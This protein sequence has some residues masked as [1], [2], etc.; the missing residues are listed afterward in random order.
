MNRLAVKLD[1]PSIT[2]DALRITEATG[3][4]AMDDRMPKL[5]E[6]DD[7]AVLLDGAGA[8]PCPA[9]DQHQHDR[10]IEIR[11]A[12]GEHIP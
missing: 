4:E 5:L 11:A 3:G 8:R 2:I 10:A 12:Q 7:D 1:F 9:A 6:H